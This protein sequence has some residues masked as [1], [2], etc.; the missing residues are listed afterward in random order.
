MKRY[1][2]YAN[3]IGMRANGFWSDKEETQKKHPMN[4]DQCKL[5]DTILGKEVMPQD[6]D[7]LV[8]NAASQTCIKIQPDNRPIDFMIVHNC[9][10]EIKTQVR[11]RYNADLQD[12]YYHN[13]EEGNDNL[14][15]DNPLPEHYLNRRIYSEDWKEIC[16]YYR[17]HK[18][19]G[20][21]Y[22][23]ETIIKMLQENGFQVSEPK[24]DSKNGG[25]MYRIITKD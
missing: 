19:H 14:V 10:E 9:N 6:L 8:I 3:S 11:G 25:K 22:G 4:G 24:K 15:R 1:I 7:L 20:G 16:A 17:A 23:K 21:T 12:F 18:P 5:R 2:N 13:V